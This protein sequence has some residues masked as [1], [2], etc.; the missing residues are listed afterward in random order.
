MFLGK[1]FIFSDGA[2]LTSFRRADGSVSSGSYGPGG[3]A[4]VVVDEVPHLVSGF[5][6]NTSNMYVEFLALISGLECASPGADV[7]VFTDQ[8][9]LVS[10]M[11]GF[12]RRRT[13]ECPS[14]WDPDLY[15]R[16]VSLCR[17]RNVSFVYH[18]ARRCGFDDC[19]YGEGCFFDFCHDVARAEMYRMDIESLLDWKGWY[20]LCEVGG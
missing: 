4:A 3:Y 18:S 13:R 17:R 16:I 7:V 19:V 5:V 14:G 15:G 6:D 11:Q 8:K 9:D 1:V 12:Y 2:C 10:M 20:K